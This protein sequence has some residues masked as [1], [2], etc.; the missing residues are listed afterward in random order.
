MLLYTNQT[1]RSKQIA[2]FALPLTPSETKLTSL[3]YLDCK[4]F[5]TITGK[6]WVSWNTRFIADLH[7]T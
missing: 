7:L 1:Y 5:F 3:S 2:A 4:G 6:M